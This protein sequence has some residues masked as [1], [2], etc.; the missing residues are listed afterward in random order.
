MKQRENYTEQGL[1][2]LVLERGDLS[3]IK[4]KKEPALLVPC[5]EENTR[6][7]NKKHRS[8]TFHGTVGI[9]FVKTTYS[10]DKMKE[11]CWYSPGEYALFKLDCK[12]TIKMARDGDI[13]DDEDEE[14]CTRGLVRLF[15]IALSCPVADLF[16]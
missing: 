6:P 2:L 14:C 15:L 13:I 16:F 3:P 9:R 7:T 8:V 12:A 11:A 4:C 10:I 5:R 1:P